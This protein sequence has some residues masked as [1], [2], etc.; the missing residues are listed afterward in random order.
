MRKGIYILPNLFTTGNLFFG[1]LSILNSWHYSLGYQHSLLKSGLFIMVAGVLDMLDG[2]VARKTNTGSR[3]GEEYDSLCD[4]VSFGVAP[5]AM[6][7]AWGHYFAEELAVVACFFHLACGAIRLA[8]FNVQNKSTEKSYFQGI[9]IPMGGMFF[10]LSALVFKPTQDIWFMQGQGFMIM[11]MFTVP[12]LMV[13]Q[14]PYLSSKSL[15]LNRRQPLFV[16]IPFVFIAMALWLKPILTLYVLVLTYIASGP[17][18]VV[19]RASKKLLKRK[20]IV[21]D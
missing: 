15:S 21:K 19:L 13:S 1:F 20:P 14:I 3:F 16:L 7:F 4:V 10:V 12:F 5:M 11:C 8:R 9:P 2:Q 18:G 6:V 17:L